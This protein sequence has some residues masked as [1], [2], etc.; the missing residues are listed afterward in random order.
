MLDNDPELL[1][2]AV[3]PPPKALDRNP[4][5]VY[6]ASLPSPESRRTLGATL[7]GLAGL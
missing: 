3:L 1:S 2:L 5:A 7:E 6:L 4:A